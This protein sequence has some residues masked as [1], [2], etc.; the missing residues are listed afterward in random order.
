MK[1]VV[2]LLR[3]F[4]LDGKVYF[5]FHNPIEENLSEGTVAHPSLWDSEAH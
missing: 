2:A 4:N 5:I 1:V 3:I